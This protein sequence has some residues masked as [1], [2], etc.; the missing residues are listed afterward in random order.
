MY[1]FLYEECIGICIY[2]DILSTLSTW[3]GTPLQLSG[4]TPR[5]SVGIVAATLMSQ[6]QI[7]VADVTVGCVTRM[8]TV[9]HQPGSN[10]TNGHN[11]SSFSPVC[12]IV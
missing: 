1:L 10:P 11:L 7:F 12:V 5:L 6:S 4:K 8:M 2:A 3:S 9:Q